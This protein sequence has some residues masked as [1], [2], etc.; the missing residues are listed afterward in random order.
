MMEKIFI[1]GEI[2]DLDEKYCLVCCR[3]LIL[4]ALYNDVEYPSGI[5]TTFSIHRRFS[6]ME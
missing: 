1:C 6:T 2:E 4:L 3:F 5:Q